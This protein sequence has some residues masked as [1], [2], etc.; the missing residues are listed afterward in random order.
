[1]TCPANETEDR[2]AGKNTQFLSKQ[3]IRECTTLATHY[4]DMD[5]KLETQETADARI[6]IKTQTAGVIQQAWDQ[7][8]EMDR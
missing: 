8:R 5:A 2:M 3:E 1:M 7:W 4:T 6:L